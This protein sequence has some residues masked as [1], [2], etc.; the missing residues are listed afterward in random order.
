MSEHD[1]ELAQQCDECGIDGREFERLEERLVKI[2]AESGVAC[3]FSGSLTKE[4]LADT[5]HKIF[6]LAGGD[7]SKF[8]AS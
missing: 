2:I 7:F 4:Q 8:Q 1:K 3:A 6:V 5:L